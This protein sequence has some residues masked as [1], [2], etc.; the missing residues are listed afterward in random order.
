MNN[1]I[2]FMFG[3]LDKYNALTQKD[4]DT[5][6]FADGQIF[7][8]DAVYS[9]K[10]VAV[11]T[12]PTKPSQGII[13]VLPDYSAKIYTGT[14]Y[15]DLAVGVIGTIEDATT[16]DGKT[17]TQG[18]LK[19]YLT[20]KLENMATVDNVQAKIDAAKDE[21]I[22]SA[23]STADA[24][25]DAKVA[26]AKQELQKQIDTKV[27]SVFRFK[28]SK[29]SL[30]EVKALKDMA[31][32]DVWHI[33]T[34]G[35]EYVYTGKE[36]ELLGFTIDLSSYAT[37]AEMTKAIN[38]KAKEITDSLASY[39]TKDEIDGK[40]Q[41]VATNIATAKS[42]AISAAA[43]DATKKADQALKDAKTYA[44]GLNTAMGT[45]VTKVEQ[46]VTWTEIA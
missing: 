37:K 18:A 14:D 6:Y 33:T 28:G 20:K 10:V 31:I 42:E 9:Q 22:K 45:R 4:N 35:K 19:T 23:V 7:K 5:L 39:Y 30:D 26:T 2:N 1:I 16:N 29:D 40:L 32:G 11:G 13:Y 36:W 3:T 25:A 27:A 43:D 46:A 38:D 21:A 34:D 15:V 12:L 41:T 24:N 44:D 8:G 17:I